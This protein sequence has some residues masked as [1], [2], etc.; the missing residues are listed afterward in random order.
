MAKSLKSYPPT[1][2]AVPPYSFSSDVEQFDLNA[3]AQRPRVRRER[4]DPPAERGGVLKALDAASTYL[5]HSIGVVNR[6]NTK[7]KKMVQVASKFMPR[8]DAY[9]G[10]RTDVARGSGDV[11]A[12]GADD[13]KT[14]TELGLADDVHNVIPASKVEE[15]VALGGAPV[16]EPEKCAG[17]FANSATGCANDCLP[18]DAS[19][20]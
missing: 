13:G 20:T 18:V 2:L 7:A 11:D 17:A 9:D 12:G 16:E 1:G 8:P 15:Q 6:V 10:E 3:R 19:T 14:R 4:L 5:D